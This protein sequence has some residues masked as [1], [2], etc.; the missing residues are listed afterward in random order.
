MIQS[1]A[2]AI[3]GAQQA[4]RVDDTFSPDELLALI[5]S[6]ARTWAAGTPEFRLSPEQERRRRRARRSAVVEITRR[7][8]E[9]RRRR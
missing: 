2:R 8:V 6:I 7:L 9:P 4:G 3:R 5:V 1:H